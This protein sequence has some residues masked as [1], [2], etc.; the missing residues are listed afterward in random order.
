MAEHD[1]LPVESNEPT[2]SA[3]SASVVFRRDDAGQGGS[4]M[5][6]AHQSL[7]DALR[8]TLRLVQFGT[9]ILAVLFVFSGA[10]TV[11]EGER[12]IRLRFGKVTQSDL[13][14]GI[15]LSWPYP[16]G[17]L[18]KIETGSRQVVE[19]TAFWP[20]LT[21][22]EKKQSI[23]TV[24]GREELDPARDGSLITADGNLAHAKWRIDY[25]RDPLAANL[26]AQNMHPEFEER[27]IRAAARRGAVQAVAGVTVDQLLKE[28]ASGPGSLADRARQIAQDTL[29]KAQSGLTIDAMVLIDK[30]PPLR[31]REDFVRVQSAEADAQASLDQARQAAS[32][33]LN[34]AAGG[35]HAD[36]AALI[37]QYEEATDALSAARVDGDASR[38]SEWEHRETDLLSEIDAL[39]ES[40]KAGGAVASKILA[41]TAFV[42]EEAQRRR[43]D[44]ARYRALLAQYQ[45]NPVVTIPMVLADGIS[46]FLTR[47]NVEVFLAPP[48]LSYVT[49]RFNRDIEAIRSAEAARKLREAQEATRRRQQEQQEAEFKTQT[50]ILTGEEG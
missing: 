12:G 46:P 17:D 36:M 16:I 9:L 29:D 6:P 4:L 41:A 42:S 32:T 49:A 43:A 20:Y 38:I 18:V 30:I 1:P 37:E 45:S 21:E 48:G 15:H 28:G 35:V 22:S 5:D 8:I 39:S 47:D 26:F 25:R 33:T 14:P 23:Q 10:K 19:E 11:R 3:R 40:P 24:Y 50:D 7:A 13:P 44:L 2:P 31:V 27:I 34:A